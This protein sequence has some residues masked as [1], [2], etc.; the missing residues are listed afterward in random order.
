MTAESETHRTSIS[1]PRG[2]YKEAEKIMH[3]QH[4]AS[5]SEFV[6][7]LIRAAV[8]QE[9][10]ARYI[11]TAEAAALAPAPPPRTPLNYRLNE[12]HSKT[13]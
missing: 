6:S 12:A 5:F 1:I 7:A 10:A 2:L 8:A 9:C 3:R 11:A 13:K 4:F